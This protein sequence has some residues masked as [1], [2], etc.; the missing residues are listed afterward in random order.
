MTLSGG[1]DQKSSRE[2]RRVP[3]RILASRREPGRVP[4]SRMKPR[5]VGTSE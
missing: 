4:T 2:T 5:M 3:R 1:C